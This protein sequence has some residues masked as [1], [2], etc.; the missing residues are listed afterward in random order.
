M[1]ASHMSPFQ[2]MYN[3]IEIFSILLSLGEVFSNK[4]H[5]P[6]HQN[7]LAI[8]ID[9]KAVISEERIATYN[10]NWYASSENAPRW[11]SMKA[12]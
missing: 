7:T 11:N 5:K 6:C 10:V 9:K 1:D 8:D 4:E 2:I 3:L 12:I